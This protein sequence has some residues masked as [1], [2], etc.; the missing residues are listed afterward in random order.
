ME[1]GADGTARAVLERD[2]RERDGKT[3]HPAKFSKPILDVVD[4]VLSE[5][6]PL[7]G[8]ILD[9]FAGVGTIQQLE[10]DGP[11]RRAW[12]IELEPEW[13]KQTPNQDRV[14]C[15]DAMKVMN[16]LGTRGDDRVPLGGVHWPT[17]FDAVV[18]SPTY[19]NR[20][21]DKHTPSPEDTSR[22][23]T[24]RHYLNRALHP[25]NSGGM[26]WGRKYREFHRHAWELVHVM[27]KPEG[28][29]VLNMSDHVRRGEIVPVTLWH[30]AVCKT[31]GFELLDEIKVETPR[32]RHGENANLR[33]DHETILAFRK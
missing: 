26:Q 7:G 33:V 16:F 6:L 11:R 27:L 30:K 19:G 14:I 10:R 13:A 18:T 31:I 9:P 17:R 20:M 15:D 22:R 32:M 23:H 25:R 4:A 21:A 1:S 3:P 5:H 2:G 12:C 24:Y 29:F 28:V 8:D